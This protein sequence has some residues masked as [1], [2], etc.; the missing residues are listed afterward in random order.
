MLLHH[1]HHQQ[2]TRVA[3]DL[4]A[5]CQQLRVLCGL[6][7]PALNALEQPCREPGGA[8]HQGL[9]RYLHTG[10]HCSHYLHSQIQVAPRPQARWQ[11]RCK[12][13]AVACPGPAVTKEWAWL[14]FSDMSEMH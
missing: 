6:F 7:S 2:Q 1:G 13:Q 12:G 3:V 5:V 10:Q 4:L 8:G 14:P 9:C 11:G